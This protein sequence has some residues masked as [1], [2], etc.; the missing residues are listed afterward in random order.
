MIPYAK[1]SFSSQEIRAV[2]HCLKNLPLTQGP[3]V[4]EFES[5]FK[6]YCEAPHAFA[7]SSGT[8][9][10]HLACL[11]AG[12]QS[13]DEVIVPAQTFVATSNA[14]LYSGAHPIFADVDPET[15]NITLENISKVISKKT[16]GIIV[17]HYAGQPVDLQ[18]ISKL[19]RKHKW[20]LIEDAAHA[21]GAEYEGKKIGSCQYSDLCTFSFHPAKNI[22]T[23][24]GGMVTTRNAALA[25]KIQD[26]RSHGLHRDTARYQHP[27]RQNYAYYEMQSLG[28]NYRLT[29][30]QAAIGVEQLKKL[31]QFQKKREVIAKIYQKNL[32][33]I[34]EISLLK[35]K[36]G[37]SAW[38]LFVIRARKAFLSR[39][40]LAKNLLANGIVPS[41]H[42]LPVPFQPFYEQQKHQASL[43]PESVKFWEE[44]ISLP[45]FPDLKKSDLMKVIQVIQDTIHENRKKNKSAFLFRSQQLGL[46]PLMPKDINA[47]YLQW[48]NDPEVNRYLA[49]NHYDFDSMADYC[50]RILSNPTQNVM[51]ALWDLSKKRHIGNVSLTHIKNRQAILGIMIGDKRYWG[52]GW[53][54]NAIEST[55]RLAFQKLGIDKINAGTLAK[56]QKALEA[57]KRV[58]FQIKK[59]IDSKKNSIYQMQLLKRNLK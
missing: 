8:A 22:T 46:C 16:K 28:F 4:K 50:N 36:W 59:T 25:L 19:A 23:G 56:N 15:G 41:L 27:E 39:D 42:Y 2:S 35:Q 54:A 3:K 7:V 21:I 13:G 48:L 1:H 6:T 34:P 14:V 18:A 24:E 17:V 33:N 10:L 57:F 52:K 31:P 47:N 40:E 29:D 11:A 43:T 49:K 53:G 26:L 51:L 20:V 30:L 32:K 9:A 58:G 45:I 38:H 37:K 5:N 55:C 44:A 12:F